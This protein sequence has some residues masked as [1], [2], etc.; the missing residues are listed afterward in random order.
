[1]IV[2]AASAWGNLLS[3]TTIASNVKIPNSNLSGSGDS[4]LTVSTFFKLASNKIHVHTTMIFFVCRLLE[5]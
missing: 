4:E 5:Y 3:R 1:M 2:V